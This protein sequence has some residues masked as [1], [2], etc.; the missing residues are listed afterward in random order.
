MSDNNDDGAILR[1]PRV[2]LPGSLDAPDATPRP[3]NDPADEHDGGQAAPWPQLPV[4]AEMRPPLHLTVPG[5]P[6]PAPASDDEGAFAPPPP[7]DPDNPTARDTAAVAMALMTALG[8]AAA[9]GMW[10]RARHRQAL[11]DK[12]RAGADKQ[13]SK[14]AAAGS[15]TKAGGGGA[16]SARGA[17]GSGSSGGTGSLLRSPAGGSKGRKPKG[18]KGSQ[19]FARRAGGGGGGRPTGGGKGPKAT[20][21]GKAAPK[22]TGAAKRPQGASTRPKGKGKATGR[23]GSGGT[24]KRPQGSGKGSTTAPKGGRK[25]I[26]QAGAD[27]KPS[28]PKGRKDDAAGSTAKPKGKGRPGGKSPKDGPKRPK[29]TWKAP[30]K[31]AKGSGKEAAGPKRWTTGRTTPAGPTPKPKG[32]KRTGHSRAWTTGTKWWKRWRTRH[33]AESGAESA[34]ETGTSQDSPRA[35]RDATGWDQP[36]S[37][38]E[39]MRPPP[40]ADQS[41]W[42]TVERVDERPW[43]RPEAPALTVGQAALTGPAPSPTAD[44]TTS[45]SADQAESPSA[46]PAPSPTPA[47]QQGAP[48]V[49][50]PARTT[51]Y[52]DAD[53][54]IYDVIEA[55]ADMA[56]EITEGVTEARDTADGCEQL[57]TRLE[58]VY[59]GVRDLKVPGVLLGMMA[60]LMDKTMT[61]KSRAEAIAA[62]LPLAAEAISVAG[63]NAAARHQGL[64]DAVR[65]AGHIRPAEREYHDE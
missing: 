17:G 19:A 16:R 12:T 27:S 6:D 10:H 64:A 30:K 13:A 43:P 50:M 34:T 51:Q 49:S 53:L 5:T 44:P 54:T 59:A 42:V 7:E 23:T 48:T 8:V 18:S 1:F 36:P 35:D 33:T 25:A 57:L 26:G 58:E 47:D 61:V 55:D 37:G 2:I 29:M 41:E 11:A 38:W 65:D 52:A 31:G 39:R 9:Q 46:D 40:G 45:P 4:V 56:E 22:G 15:G 3:D 24:P 21:G 20:R 28:K 60:L 63:T 14:S 32:S 62:N